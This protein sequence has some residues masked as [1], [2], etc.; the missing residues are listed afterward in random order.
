MVVADDS[1]PG[2]AAVPSSGQ[3]GRVRMVD[4]AVDAPPPEET[5][6]GWSVVGAIVAIVVV[7][8]MVALLIIFLWAALRTT[9]T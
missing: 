6:P 9:P 2:A 1:A 5:T 4:E 3:I 8:L 7:A